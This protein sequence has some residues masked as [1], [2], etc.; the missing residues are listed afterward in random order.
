MSWEKEDAPLS[1][2]ADRV[3]IVKADRALYVI[4]PDRL[5]DVQLRCRR[6][7]QSKG[8]DRCCRCVLI[9][10]YFYINLIKHNYMDSNFTVCQLYLNLRSVYRG[11]RSPA[12]LESHFVLDC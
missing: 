1:I 6:H 9:C 5:W 8:G 2:A 4:A 11:E 3:R 12:W 10:L 7:T